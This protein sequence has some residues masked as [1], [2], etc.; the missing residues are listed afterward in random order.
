MDFSNQDR[1]SPVILG[2]AKNPRGADV[3]FFA[4]PRMTFAIFIGMFIRTGTQGLAIVMIQGQKRGGGSPGALASPKGNR[5]SGSK[6][7]GEA[8]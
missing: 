3:R 7:A 8:S 5:Q 2:A 4:A 6:H 1:K